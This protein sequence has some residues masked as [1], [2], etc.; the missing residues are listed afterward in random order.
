MANYN[1]SKF[2]HSCQTQKSFSDFYKNCSKPDGLSGMCKPC[3][4]IS[5]QKRYQ[6]K[7]GKEKK[8]LYTREYRKKNTRKDTYNPIKS[9]KKLYGIS[10]TDYQQ[11]LIDQ[12]NQC[13]ICKK[14]KPLVVDHCHQTGKIRGLLCHR[15]NSSLAAFGDNIAGVIVAVDYLKFR[16]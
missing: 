15:C 12:Q 8:R 7:N 14:S 9:R 10:E 4:L 13:G 3:T 1:I 2:C 5:N 6:T 11:M 16:S